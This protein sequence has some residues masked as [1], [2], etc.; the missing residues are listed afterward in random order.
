MTIYKLKLKTTIMK[1]I[2][3]I[4]AH[5]D[6]VADV[7][8]TIKDSLE[9]NV[10]TIV[11]N[12]VNAKSLSAIL[13]IRKKYPKI[14]KV[15]AGLYPEESLKLSD[16]EKIKKLIL[17]N[18]S[19]IIA[20]GEIGLDLHHTDKNFN[21]QKEVFKKQLD[22]AEELNL[23]V[24][25]HTRKAELQVL[26]ILQNYPSLTKI[27]HCFMAKK[28]LVKKAIDMECYFSIPA[29]I[30]KSE[31]FQ[32]ITKTSPKDKI[33]TETDSPYLSPLKG[34][35]NTPSNIHYSIEKIS[36]IWNSSRKE[37]EEQIANNFNSIFNIATNK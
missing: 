10:K 15:A 11:T 18:E 13:K 5:L 16:F 22:L 24:I 14:V 36:E 29:I 34:K 31:Q 21:I 2:H 28:S 26:E 35:E 3:D 7:E 19:N 9:N 33:L 6:M 27:L 4:H 23:P 12:S 37:T 30:T 17:D 20:I 32:Y 25:I 8:K 1:M